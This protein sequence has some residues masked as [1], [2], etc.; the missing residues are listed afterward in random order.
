MSAFQP[1][2]DAE[3]QPDESARTRVADSALK[4]FAA[5]GYAETTVREIIEAAGVTRPVLYYYFQN[6]AELFCYLIETEFALLYEGMDTIVA[7]HSGCRERLKALVGFVFERAERA[8]EVVRF[9]L[10]FFFS[11]P[12]EPIRIDSEKLAQERLY[13]IVAIMADGLTSGEIG[14]G[15]PGAL[16]LAFSGMMDLHVM[17]KARNS[18]MV[19][20][21]ELGGALVD[22]FM[23]GAAHNGDGRAQLRYALQGIYPATVELRAGTPD[24]EREP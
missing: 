18:G 4:L 14:G 2:S 19:L 21:A 24:D 20:S 11:P 22:L 8:P 6:K 17:A 13:R 15:D 7:R 3:L 5:K 23:D 10:R 1:I 16:A 12:D 9:L